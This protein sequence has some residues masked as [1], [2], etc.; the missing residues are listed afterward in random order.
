MSF[1][2][3]NIID[4]YSV[5]HVYY[6]I[7]FVFIVCLCVFSFA[8]RWE[9]TK[10]RPLQVD[11]IYDMQTACQFSKG[12]NIYNDNGYYFRTPFIAHF[13]SMFCNGNDSLVPVM[14]TRKFMWVFSLA[15]LVLVYLIAQ[16]VYGSGIAI[17]APLILCSFTTFMDHSLYVRPDLLG[18]FLCS[19]ALFLVTYNSRCLYM[20]AGTL[21]GLAAMTTQ[22]SLYPIL[23]FII[24]LVVRHVLA[25]EGFKELK[26]AIIRSFS[27]SL[28]GF[29]LLLTIYIGIMFSNENMPQFFH[30]TIL[31]AADAGLFSHVYDWTWPFLILTIQ[32]NPAVWG[33]GLS[34]MV[35]ALIIAFQ[36]KK[37]PYENRKKYALLA[38]IGVWGII[39]FAFT[40]KHNVKFPYY[41]INISPILSICAAGPIACIFHTI[42]S[43]V[44][45][46]IPLGLGLRGMFIVM[47]TF[48]LLKFP[49]ERHFHNLTAGNLLQQQAVISRL[50]LITDTSD[51]IFDGMGLA[52]TRKRQLRTA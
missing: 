33:L 22:K 18:T 2:V 34:G 32:R 14:K 46:P 6:R 49:Y 28:F 29:L 24:S 39:Q 45:R 17:F 25:S 19:G 51:A 20:L 4:G 9:M 44:F 12:E 11:E 1:N 52:A 40:L 42:F 35:W 15:L 3:N 41:F 10:I 43:T 37:E 23:A 13:G 16:R 8:A 27:Y 26:K 47:A 30:Q 21:L 31:D 5:D 38:M 7:A 50:D 48:G 36:A